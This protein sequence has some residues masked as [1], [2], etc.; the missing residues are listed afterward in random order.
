VEL[1][2]LVRKGSNQKT[3]IFVGNIHKNTKIEELR[4]LFEIYG[5][6]VEADI[7]DTKYPNYAFVHMEIESEACLAIRGLD[8]Y[9][10]H[11]LLL[12][13]QESTS[14]VRKNSV[15]GNPGLGFRC[16]LASHWCKECPQN[17]Q[18]GNFRDFH[19]YGGS[20]H[21]SNLYDPYQPPSPSYG[22]DWC[23]RYRTTAL[24]FNSYAFVEQ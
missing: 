18:E 11:G 21:Y 4:E 16:G 20:R 8:G 24:S 19:E 3:K 1:S 5:T 14:T 12:R 9:E 7:Q 23:M 10:F 2:K 15:I 22:R 17:M 13:V 6:V